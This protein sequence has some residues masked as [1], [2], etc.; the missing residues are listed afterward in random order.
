[1][2]KRTLSFLVALSMTLGLST[3]A[4]ASAEPAAAAVES[5]QNTTAAPEGT[6]A[7]VTPSAETE[8]HS[9]SAD[10]NSININGANTINI[11]GA[12]SSGMENARMIDGTRADGIVNSNVMTTNI[13]EN[14][15]KYNNMQTNPPADSMAPSRYSNTRVAI[16]PDLEGTKYEEAAELLGALGIMVGDAE[17]GNFRPSDSIRRSEMAKVAVYSVGLEDVAKGA[18]QATRFPD[19][20]SDHWA[21]GPINVADQQGMIVGDDVGTFRPDDDVSFEEAVTMVVRALGY[22]PAAKANGGYPTGYMVV[23]SSNQLLKGINAAGTTP[24]T[25]GDVAQLIFNAMTVNMMEQ[26]GFG[27]DVSYEVVDKTLLYDKL[28]VEK[29][30]GQIKG[31]SET[32][33]TGGSTTARDRIQINDDIFYAGETRAKQLLGYN[34]IYYARIDTN[35][36]EKTLIVTR[37]Q[38]NK[39]NSITI[40]A[41]DIVDVTGDAT[42]NKVVSYWRS[43][44]DRDPKNVTID[45][46]PIYIYNG[47]FKETVEITALKPTSGNLVLLDSDSNG[48]YDIV[49]VNHFKNIVVDTISTVTGRVTD[50]YLNGSLVFDPDNT[51]V[52]YTLLKDGV[53][54][55]VGDLAEWNVLS[56][57]ISEDNELIKA[58]VSDK[59]VSGT[60][61]EVN[62]KGFRI[63]GDTGLYKKAESYPNEI[64]L[65][66]SGTF[67]IDIE[68]NIAAVNTRGGNDQTQTRENYAYLVN[69]AEEGTFETNVQFKLFTAKGETTVLTSSTKMRF[70]KDY[71]LEPTEVLTRLESG[72]TV[73]PQLITYDVNSSGRITGISVAADETATGTPNPDEFTL[74]VNKKDMV[75]KSASGKLDNVSVG[76]D[77]IIFDIPATADNDTD[78]FAVRG[79]SMFS[80]D[81]QYDALVYDMQENYVANVIVVTSSTG[82]TSAESPIVVVDNVSETQNENFDYVDKL[83]G[84]ENGKEVD[85]NASDR[86]ILVKNNSE[87]L[88]QGDIIQYKT[89]ARGEIDGIT[90]LFDVSKKDVEAITELSTDLTTVYGRVTKKFAGSVNVEVN[91]E[92]H[93]YALPEN[94]TVYLYDSARSN[95]NISV[96][97][98]ADIEI[99]ETGNEVRLFLKIFE[100]KVQEAVIVR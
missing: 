10:T 42:T 9:A 86:N 28:N 63:S 7:A 78:R 14:S 51:N 15:S 13:T 76:E 4:F 64:A 47:K 66:D 59:S 93:N 17:D 37:E 8:T 25:R 96:V 72:G 81:G 80:N 85:I 20:V 27:T 99:Y 34:V 54:I 55:E 88:E 98:A 22:E 24:A 97:S 16:A 38:P 3:L 94:M 18:T 45:K 77:T 29:G 79:K 50:K 84:F 61:T 52:E 67:Y 49:F 53:E 31:T 90:L 11:N 1:M 5:N 100:D 33:L 83:Y 36:D 57:T 6:S 48:T 69:A 73:T 95:N 56:Y 2:L 70:N 32:T 91:G 92:I 68:G 21:N 44:N 89:N 62:S 23:A 71:G 40:P 26:I 12:A 74:N 75:Y 82:I 35:T 60:I 65:R 41:K 58:Y 46:D 39:N 30:Y 19:V 43:E 87:K